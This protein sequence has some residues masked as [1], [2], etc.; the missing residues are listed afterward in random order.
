MPLPFAPLDVNAPKV[1]GVFLTLRVSDELAGGQFARETRRSELERMGQ[2]ATM[3][4]DISDTIAHG[5][6]G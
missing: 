6:S 4:S 2:R 3:L 1:C 5:C